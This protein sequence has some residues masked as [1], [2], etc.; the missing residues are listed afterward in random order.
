MSPI[1]IHKNQI[2]HNC[3]NVCPEVIEVERYYQQGRKKRINY[4]CYNVNTNHNN[5]DCY[6]FYLKNLGLKLTVSEWRE[7]TY[8]AIKSIIMSCSLDNHYNNHNNNDDDDT[9]TTIVPDT[10]PFEH[11][12]R[13]AYD[14]N[15]TVRSYLHSVDG[16]PDS[17]IVSMNNPRV[18]DII[19][20]LIHND[21]DVVCLTPD[22][23]DAPLTFTWNRI[24]GKGLV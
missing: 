10:T 7:D 22:K 17:K 14:I 8:Q 5:N 9:M 2:C 15:P 6:S 18:D 1:I 24:K 16:L 23:D 12:L 20:Q 4:L 21:N 3:G 19:W 11:V 13:T